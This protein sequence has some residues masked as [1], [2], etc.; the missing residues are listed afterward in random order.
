[1]ARVAGISATCVHRL[2]A[3]ND[4]KPHLTHTFKRSYDPHFEKKF[5]DAGSISTRQT[6]RWCSAAM[7]KARF[8]GAHA[9]WPASGDRTYPHAIA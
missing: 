6:R 1:M 7:R 8:P 5:W 2:W 9:T 3:A 4:L